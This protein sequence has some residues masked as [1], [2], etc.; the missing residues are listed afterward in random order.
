[1]KMKL[2]AKSIYNKTHLRPGCDKSE[3]LCE[4]LKRGILT[5]ELNLISKMGFEIEIGGDKKEFDREMVEL[6]RYK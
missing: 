2:L 4:L 3:A 6:E 1:M 5:N